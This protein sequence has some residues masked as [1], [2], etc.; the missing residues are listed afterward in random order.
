MC[1]AST[2]HGKAYREGGSQSAISTIKNICS[3]PTG[4]IQSFFLSIYRDTGKTT[5]T[6]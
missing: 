1:L 6:F 2:R 3:S 4:K 5:N